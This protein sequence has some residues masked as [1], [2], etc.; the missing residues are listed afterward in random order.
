MLRN[1]A[2]HLVPNAPQ[3]QT[4]FLPELES[5]RGLAALAV[6]VEHT[7]MYADGPL[8]GWLKN[9]PE[10][11]HHMIWLLHV[12][13]N[14][15]A[16][17]VLFFVISGFVLARQMESLQGSF[18]RR[19]L[20]YLL[21]RVFRIVP[22]MWVAILFAWGFAWVW[23]PELA[24]EP[25]LLPKTLLLQD[26][27]LDTP[28]WSLKAEL[29]C[30]FAFPLLFALRERNRWLGVAL[31]A[32]LAAALFLPHEWQGVDTLRYLVFFQIGILVGT[33]GAATVQA[34]APGWRGAAF[35]AAWLVLELSSQLWPF[36]RELFTFHEDRAWL[37]LDIP[38]AY[39][40]LSLVAHGQLR[41]VRAVLLSPLAR[42]FG[43]ISFSLYLL[44]YIFSDSMWVDYAGSAHFAF[45]RD[46]PL[47]FGLMYFLIVF[48]LSLP[49]AMLSYQYV[50]L[51]FHQ[52]GRRV[53]RW[54]E[55]R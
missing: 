38:A 8:F 39:L 25:W 52:L 41:A 19:H 49:L 53:G 37:M 55:G 24:R 28:L 7:L 4:G 51:P 1:T 34:I 11:G 40:L 33:H 46:W 14:G 10:P 6:V 17:V 5:L 35:A 48:Y 43:K 44:H 47:S 29:M 45:L 32:P 13:F 42:F 20:A 15:R 22:V 27:R 18:L 54:V 31:L 9:H 50:E 23:R 16:A 3:P 30:S 36:S 12:L 26:F 21:R 2:L